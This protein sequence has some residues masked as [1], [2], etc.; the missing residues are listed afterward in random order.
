MNFSDLAVGDEISYRLEDGG[1]IWHGRVLLLFPDWQGLR[2]E[3]LDRG[4]HTGTADVLHIS[5]VVEQ[6]RYRP[7]PGPVIPA[8]RNEPVCVRCGAQPAAG[9]PPRC[10]ACF[11]ALS[12]PP[13]PFRRLTK[14]EH[15]VLRE[16]IR[17]RRSA[18]IAA[19]L[20]ISESAVDTYVSR[21]CQRLGLA[22]RRDLVRFVYQQDDR[23]QDDAV[24]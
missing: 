22:S 9:N 5:Q 2:V 11:A 24:E 20:H 17:P 1:E 6:T 15:A 21:I 7:A 12:A 14:Q 10:E 23:F 4:K 16:L 13:D 18:E 8:P 3:L 19:R